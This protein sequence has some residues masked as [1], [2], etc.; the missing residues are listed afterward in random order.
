MTSMAPRNEAGIPLIND[1]LHLSDFPN[2]VPRQDLRTK[3]GYVSDFIQ[4]VPKDG[5][6]ATEQTE[7]WMAYTKTTL[8][9]VF[10]CHDS[11]RTWFAIT[12]RAAKTSL[13]TTR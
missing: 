6:A 9:F 5:D 11:H 1:A 13:S 12:L 8:Y 7:V 2:M 10:I 4:T 3:L